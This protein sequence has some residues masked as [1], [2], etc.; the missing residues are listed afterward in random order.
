MGVRC[1]CVASLLLCKLQPNRKRWNGLLLGGA[2][3]MDN[4]RCDLSGI[5]FLREGLTGLLTAWCQWDSCVKNCH[6]GFFLAC[7][8]VFAERGTSQ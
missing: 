8:C 4:T 5:H 7:G 2:G 6:N 3:H 1:R